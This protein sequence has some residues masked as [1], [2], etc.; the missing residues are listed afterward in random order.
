M[1]R[2]SQGRGSGSISPTYCGHHLVQQSGIQSPLSCNSPCFKKKKRLNFDLETCF[3]MLVL[4]TSDQN[5]WHFYGGLRSSGLLTDWVPK[6]WDL[7]EL[8]GTLLNSSFLWLKFKKWCVISFWRRRRWRTKRRRQRRRKS[9]AIFICPS[10]SRSRKT[11]WQF[12]TWVKSV[13]LHVDTIDLFNKDTLRHGGSHC[14]LCR[15]CSSAI[16][17][18]TPTRTFLSI[19]HM[20]Q[21]YDLY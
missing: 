11:G 16:G 6:P 21:L 13:L 19:L 1:V 10:R 17:L 7:R 9:R 5:L 20:G 3:C 8:G 14:G 4:S 15:M 12:G 2:T 18:E